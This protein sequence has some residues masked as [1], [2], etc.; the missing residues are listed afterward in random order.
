MFAFADIWEAVARARGDAPAQ[1]QGD[2][3]VT[4]TEFDQR[5]DAVASALLEVGAGQQA[6][7]ANYLYNGPEYLEAVFATVKAGMVPVNT[8]YRYGAEEL[9]YLWDNADCEAVVFHGEFAETV[10]QVRK[11]VPGVR[12]WLWVDDGSGPCPDWATP[13]EDVAKRSV[14]GPVRGPWGRSPEDLIFIYT[15]GTTGMPKGVMWRQGDLGR[16]A[17][18]A[19]DPPTTVDDVVANLTEP[20]PVFLPACPLMHATGLLTAFGNVRQGGVVVTLAGRKLDPVELLDAVEREKVS[21]MAIV[22]DAFAKPILRALDAEPN[23][24]DLDS[25]RAIISSGV[26]WSEPVKQGLLAHKPS[27]ILFDS[28]GSSEAVGLGQSMSTGEGVTATASF[29][30]GENS[31][32]ITDDDRDVV[33][34]SGEIGRLA[35][36]GMIPMGY[37]KDETK[38]A[39]TFRVIDGVRYV[40]PGDFATVDEDGTVHLLG[41][42]SQCINTGGEKVFPEEIEE[43]LKERP[44]VFDAAVVGIPDEKWGEAVC[45]IVE[46]KPGASVDGD[47]LIEHVRGRLARFKAPKHVVVVPTVGRAPNGKLDYRR[48]KTEATEAVLKLA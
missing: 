11:R 19:G 22:G 5:A 43:V 37:Y 24:W 35:R 29:R 45:A 34:G 48:L 16:G 41:R 1:V 26:M 30:L 40:I 25:L 39:A 32:I 28:L 31:R 14:E 7:V 20:A 21:S 18:T 27:L 3:R 4:W 6:K 10:D 42:G 47:A 17:V 13:Y 36:S 33:P 23:R 8:N 38:T 15:G 12:L 2:R 44:E 46:P 9:T